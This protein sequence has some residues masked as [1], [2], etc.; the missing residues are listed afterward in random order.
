MIGGS[1]LS[2]LM[3]SVGDGS[4]RALLLDDRRRWSAPSS[5]KSVNPPYHVV[6]GDSVLQKEEPV[7]SSLVKEP[8]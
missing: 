4:S 3:Q 5:I 2:F 8:S 6:E 1:P 7:D